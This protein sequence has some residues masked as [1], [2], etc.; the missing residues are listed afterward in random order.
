MAANS[1]K[2]P[3]ST[4][5]CLKCGNKLDADNFFAKVC[6]S[7]KGVKDQSEPSYMRVNGSAPCN[8]CEYQKPC[9]ILEL[10]CPAFRESMKGS[11]YRP[12]SYWAHA[13]RK[14][15]LHID[16]STPAPGVV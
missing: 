14:P 2:N 1:Q 8:G 9:E 4:K 7:C 3:V 15:D 5:A 10:C 11:G 6:T 12:K 13:I 16:G